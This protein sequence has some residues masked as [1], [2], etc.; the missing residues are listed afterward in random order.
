MSTAES[1]EPRRRVLLVLSGSESYHS[2]LIIGEES[3][4]EYSV[5]FCFLQQY[6]LSMRTKRAK[7]HMS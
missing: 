2:R 6:C 7:F 4:Q 1:L 3:S 5:A